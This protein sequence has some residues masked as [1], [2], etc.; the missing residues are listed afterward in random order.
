MSTNLAALAWFIPAGAILAKLAA[1]MAIA[2]LLGA[3]AGAH[4]AIRNGAAFVR[5]VFIVVVLLLIARLIRD[6]LAG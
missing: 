5:R 6:S 1:A 2:N 3:W 4:L